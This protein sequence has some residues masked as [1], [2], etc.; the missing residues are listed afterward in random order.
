MWRHVHSIFRD[1]GA[2]NAAWVW[3]PNVDP[4]RR[5]ARLARLYPGNAYVDWTCLDGYN[6]NDPWTDFTSLFA[7]TYREVTKIAPSKP[8]IIG[9]VGSTESGGSKAAWIRDMFAALQNRFPKVRAML[10]FDQS[11]RGPGGRSDWSVRSS[12]T[13]R[14]AF[15]AGLASSSIGAVPRRT[16]VAPVTRRPEARPMRRRR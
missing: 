1:V 3:C 6:G 4:E 16:R 7:S 9:E 15:A 5:F 14:S 10:W 13:S 8:M 12:S 2:T 11:V